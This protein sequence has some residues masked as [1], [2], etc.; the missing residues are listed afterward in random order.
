MADN[1]GLEAKLADLARLHDEVTRQ[2]S[3]PEVHG[4]P[5]QLRRLGR[6][7]ARLDPIVAAYRELGDVRGQL[8]GARAI[9]DGESDDDMRTMAR[10]EVAELETREAALVDTLRVA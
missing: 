2:L 1:G 7:L 4:D 10:E 3:T 8:V 9:R 5:S 6:E